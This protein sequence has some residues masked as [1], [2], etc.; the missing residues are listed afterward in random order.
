ML[1][2]I[3]YFY[4][5]VL[6]TCDPIFSYALFFMKFPLLQTLLYSLRVQSFYQETLLFHKFPTF[7]I[8]FYSQYSTLSITYLNIFIQFPV[9]SLHLLMLPLSSHTHFH[10]FMS[11]TLSHVLSTSLVAFM[12]NVFYLQSII[13]A[14][15]TYLQNQ[16]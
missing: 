3:I 8:Q 2:V 1:C 5:F 6:V 4:Y 7:V 11:S 15:W 12:H 10:Y 13:I 14:S 16:F 9:F